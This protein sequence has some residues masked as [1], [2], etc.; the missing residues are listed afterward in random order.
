MSLE[1]DTTPPVFGDYMDGD[2]ARIHRVRIVLTTDA[3]HLHLADAASPVVWPLDVLRRIPD[4]ADRAS[5][6]LGRLGDHPARVRIAD[7]ELARQLDARCPDLRRRHRDPAVL[8]RLA[9]LSAAAFASVALIVFVLVP[10]MADQLATMLP[11]AGEQAFGDTT[12]EQI[13]TALEQEGAVPVWDCDAPRGRLALDV[14][15]GRLTENA[16]LEYELRLHVLDH[17]M[18]NAFALPGGHIILFRGLLEDA[19]SA[20]EVAAVLAHEIGH[21]HHRDPT[22]LALRSA[23]SVGVL[24]LLLGDF[25]GGTAVL[26]LAEKLIQASYSRGAEAAADTYAHER[27]AAARLPSWP[28]ADFFR[29][30]RDGDDD[31]PG[32]L[33]HLASHPD[34]TRRANEANAADTVGPAFDRV[35]NDQQWRALRSICD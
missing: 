30:L 14:M 23:G 5:V 2:T 8:R 26:F 18:V 16:G 33:S 21:V 9:G 11:T 10:V 29:R 13:R 12:Y 17:D 27:L 1:T 28:M 20:E 4:Q 34:L 22:R 19:Q 6:V 7:P 15:A 25:A 32:L 3:L 24:G 31:A 35:L